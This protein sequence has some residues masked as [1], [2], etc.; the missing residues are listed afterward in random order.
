MPIAIRSIRC[1]IS[2]R[3]LYVTVNEVLRQI[4]RRRPE[5]YLR[6]KRRLKAIKW[7]PKK[8]E[9]KSP[10]TLGRIRPRERHHIS[11][12]YGYEGVGDLYLARR[13][14]KEEAWVWRAVIAHE[15]GHIAATLWDLR[16]TK[17]PEANWASEL[18][19]DWYAYRWG[20]GH[21]VRR[22][23]R[24]RA[25]VHHFFA[26]GEEREYDGCRYRVT[27]HFVVHLIPE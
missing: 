10:A 4:K 25:L 7:L 17:A 19:A 26:P 13:L 18:T 20:F 21:D 1:N 5:D 23:M 27:R 11:Y 16:R 15:F 9:Q 8:E 24:R 22:F 2:N 3:R 6:I 14:S 12:G